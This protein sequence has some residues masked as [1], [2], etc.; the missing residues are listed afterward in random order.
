[1]DTLSKIMQFESGEMS[2]GDIII[3]FQELIDSGMAWTLQGSYGRLAKD[4]IV[5]GHCKARGGI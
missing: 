1:M 5:L 3:F 2:E 4:L